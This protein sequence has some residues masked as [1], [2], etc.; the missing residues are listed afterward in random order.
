MKKDCEELFIELVSPYIT[1][2]EVSKQ[3]GREDWHGVFAFAEALQAE[4]ISL[5]KTWIVE[6]IASNLDEVKDLASDLAEIAV[7]QEHE[8]VQGR[9]L[10]DHLSTDA[11]NLLGEIQGKLRE[12]I[13][14]N[15]CACESGP[16]VTAYE[17][18]KFPKVDKTLMTL[19]ALAG[20]YKITKV[21]DDGD[22]TVEA[23]NNITY[24]VTTDGKFFPE[25]QP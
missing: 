2:R 3:Y 10:S 12:V 5:R 9:E 25:G 14:D 7:K 16:K 24:V 6:P 17:P 15:V 1:A 18:G 22:L 11:I 23:G 19:R 4:M 13:I 8:A 20:G 21:H